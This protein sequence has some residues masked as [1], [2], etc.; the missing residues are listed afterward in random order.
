MK[1]AIKNS[2]TPEE[3]TAIKPWCDLVNDLQTQIRAGAGAVPA[4]GSAGQRP[5]QL[6][7]GSGGADDGN[8]DN[9]YL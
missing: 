2:N 1:Q 9:A 5:S 7:A 6:P 4:N 8:G 3:L